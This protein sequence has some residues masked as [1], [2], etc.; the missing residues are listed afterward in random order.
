LRVTADTNVLVRASVLDD[1]EQA[2][3]AVELLLN[4][5]IVAVPLPALCEYAWVLRQAYKRSPTEVAGYIRNLIDSP[6]VLIDLPAVEAGLAMLDAGGDFA[7]GVIA[8]TGRQLGGAVFASFDRQAVE[9]I[10]ASGGETHL[11][12]G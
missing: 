6:N 1:R 9:L 8:F 4:A 2:E 10:A 5:E 3:L 12:G 11:L 7:D